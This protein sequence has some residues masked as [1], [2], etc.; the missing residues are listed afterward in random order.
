MISFRK[1][2]QIMS[3]LIPIFFKNKTEEEEV[4]TKK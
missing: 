4:E 2:I 1:L 3:N